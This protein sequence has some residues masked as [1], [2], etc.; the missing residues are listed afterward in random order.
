MMNKLPVLLSI[1]HGGEEIPPELQDRI[2]LSSNDILEDIDAFTRDIYDL[3][4]IVFHV[5]SSK[6]ARTFV[7]LNRKPDD[8]P[9]D[10]PDGVVKSHTCYGK[11][12]YQSGLEPNDTLTKKLLDKYYFPYHQEIQGILE[13][14]GISIALA[15]DCHSMAAIPPKISPDRGKKRPLV[16]LGNGNYR[17]CSQATIKK[18]ANCFQRTFSLNT[19]EISINKPFAGGYIT[20]TYGEHSIPW[21]QVELNRILYLDQSSVHKKNIVKDSTRIKEIHQKFEHAMR[22][23]FGN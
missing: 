1:P 7:D 15:L 19:K 8:L 2:I 21:I 4:G 9:P 5:I 6:I 16:C 23:F 20:R 13:D 12:I 18:L 10:N 3:G 22:L 11:V 17:T 14:K